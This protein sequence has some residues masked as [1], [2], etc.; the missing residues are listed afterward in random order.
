MYLDLNKP[1]KMYAEQKTKFQND[2]ILDTS[3]N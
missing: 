3:L 1:G 2:S